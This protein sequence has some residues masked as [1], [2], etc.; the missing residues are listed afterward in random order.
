MRWKHAFW[1]QDQA[2]YVFPG[3]GAQRASP[4]CPLALAL[5]KTDMWEGHAGQTQANPFGFHLVVCMSPCYLGSR[6]SSSADRI[7]A[8]RGNLGYLR[9]RFRKLATTVAVLTP[10][11]RATYQF[12]STQCLT[13]Y[14]GMWENTSSCLMLMRL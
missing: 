8:Q 11:H 2:E 14:Q 3:S 9:S 10:E 1:I 5:A 13:K 12:F 4:L 7:C 6:Y